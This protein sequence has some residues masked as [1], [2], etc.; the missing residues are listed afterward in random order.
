M[1]FL[2]FHHSHTSP[3]LK[4]FVLQNV[5]LAITKAYV[6]GMRI[7]NVLQEIFVIAPPQSKSHTPP[8]FGTASVEDFRISPLFR[9][10]FVGDC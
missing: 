2:N 7:R 6:Y 8:G 4:E 10:L 9:G 5:G 1:P 3:M